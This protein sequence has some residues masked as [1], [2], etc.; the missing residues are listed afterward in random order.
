MYITALSS[1]IYAGLA[2]NDLLS[3][4]E[5]LLVNQLLTNIPSPVRVD[6]RCGQLYELAFKIINVIDRIIFDEKTIE[7][8]EGK[9]DLSH[10]LKI[11]SKE[12]GSIQYVVLYDCLSVPELLTIASYLRTEGYQTIFPQLYILNPLGLTRFITKQVLVTEATMEDVLKTIMSSLKAI[13]GSLI[14]EID[15]KL[16]DYGFDL[17]EFIRNVDIEKVVSKCKSYAE[18]GSTLVM[19]DHGYDIFYDPRGFYVS[20]GGIFMHQ[21]P[22]TILNFSKIAPIMITFKR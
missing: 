4:R 14:R 1:F 22:Q 5:K 11:L 7:L 6:V 12:L 9:A 10:V 2:K 15:K 19:S 20:H 18:E 16:H 21:E 8:I 17:R 3:F 13:K